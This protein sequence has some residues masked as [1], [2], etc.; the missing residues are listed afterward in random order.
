MVEIGKKTWMDEIG[1][2]SNQMSFLGGGAD[3]GAEQKGE[4]R[5]LA[6]MVCERLL[7]C[8]SSLETFIRKEEVKTEEGSEIIR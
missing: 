4:Q 3:G 2:T 5:S 6:N 7:T 8:P 1:D